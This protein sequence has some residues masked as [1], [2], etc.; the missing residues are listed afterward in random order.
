MP[1]AVRDL[2]AMEPALRERLAQR[3]DQLALNPRPPGVKKLSGHDQRYRV[4]AGD[5]RI[6]YE[7]HDDK[8]LVLVLRVRHRREVYR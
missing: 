1:A 8:V 5:H 7:I 3:I 2:R 4:R 6:I